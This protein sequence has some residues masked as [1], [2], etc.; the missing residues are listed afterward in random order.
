MKRVFLLPGNQERPEE[1]CE[2]LRLLIAVTGLVLIRVTW[3]LWFGSAEIFPRVPLVSWFLNCPAWCDPLA[4]GV[5]ALSLG[6]IFVFCGEDKVSHLAT[7]IFAGAFFAAVL[8][9][10]Q[11]LQPWAW[12]FCILLL[13]MVLLPPQKA[14]FCLRLIVASIY[15]HSGLS[16][17]DMSFLTTHGEA[18][19]SVITQAVGWDFSSAAP[20]VRRA[21]VAMLPLGEIAVAAGLL[22]PK[23]RRAAKWFSVGMHLGLL[24]ILGPWG[25]GHKPG[26]L[27]WNGYFIVQNLVLFHPLWNPADW[28]E[29]K[30]DDETR[31]RYLLAMLFTKA[32]KEK[33]A[34]EVAKRNSSS[35]R[36]IRHNLRLA[37]G[38][39]LVAA[40]VLL[41]F[42]EPFGYCDHWPAWAVYA[43][44]PERTRVYVAENRVRDLPAKL[45]KFVTDEQPPADAVKRWLAGKPAWRRLR[46][47]RWSLDALQAPLYPQDRFQIGVALAVAKK[48]DLKADLRV[49]IDGPADRWTGIRTTKILSGSQA[50]EK[51]DRQYRLNALPR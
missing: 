3:P 22:I 1:I 25:L 15:L 51:A 43:S 41:P 5:M 38:Y 26:V 12:E 28:D 18:F 30:L 39:S 16:K 44:R 42:L 45:Q 49:E 27:I 47:D 11:R 32:R 36:L 13:T 19:V 6:I 23:T 21:I 35:F 29:P 48:Y 14:V 31:C 34:A 20:G 24:W 33:Q 7:L 10:Q 37:V 50:L 4:S 9:D 17:L 46:I 2:K 8:L 40:V